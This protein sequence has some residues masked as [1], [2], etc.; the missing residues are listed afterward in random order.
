MKIGIL[1]LPLHTNYG[2]ILQ[3]YALQT[4][5]ERM[6]HEV[7]VIDISHKVV[8]KWYKAPLSYVRRFFSLF[9][10]HPIPIF[11]EQKLNRERSLAQINTRPFINR[12]I[13][14]YCVNYYN[15]INEK[16]FDA[17]VV[18]SDQIWRPV[19]VKNLRKGACIEEAYLQFAREWE[20]KRIAY[21]AS[22]GTDEWEYTDDETRN[23]MQLIKKFDMVSVREASGVRL[24]KEYFEMN[25]FH[26]LD[27][28]MLLDKADYVKLFEQAETPKSN[29]D[30][31]IYVL[32]ETSETTTLIKHVSE[33]YNMI[34]FRTNVEVENKKLPIEQRIQLPL[35]QWLR[36]FYDAKLVVT[37][38]FHACVFSILFRK[39][40]IVVGNKKRGLARFHSLLSM[41][42]LESRLWSADADVDNMIIP[43]PQE[44]FALLD[45]W[46]N[47]SKDFLKASLV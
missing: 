20:V 43:L 45:E 37:D 46:R 18:G 9:T 41:F 23:C 28:T 31:L 8:L 39:P 7:K 12:Y 16:D 36:G 29:G 38:S 1:T 6:G 10:S 24:C 21:A 27:P 13:H 11:F 34:P 2:G 40:F 33:K 44:A 42:G 32:D 22:F 14:S 15:N 30:L 17:Y 26:V 35:D 3:A 4:I 5:L 47:K 25:A 19:Y